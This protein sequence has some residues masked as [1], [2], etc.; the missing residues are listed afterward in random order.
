M[1]D[2]LGKRKLTL[3]LSLFANLSDSKS[4]NVNFDSR[5][6]S[7]S[8]R[9][10]EREVVGL[11]IVAAMNDSKDGSDSIISVKSSRAAS[12]ATMSPRSRPIPIVPSSAKP[13]LEKDDVELSESYTCVISHLG[14]NSI[15]KR[16]YFD[17]KIAGS[18][19]TTILEVNSLS[20]GVFSESPL[21]HG[22]GYPAMVPFQTAD[23]L[24]SCHLCK[25]MLHGL[26]IFMYRGEKAFCSPECRYK[27]IVNDE[28]KEKWGL[29]VMKPLDYY[30]SP[31]SSPMMFFAGVAAA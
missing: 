6:S 23:F 8:P 9:N 19:G 31:C 10:F 14:N 11:G 30:A 20:S 1:A 13:M 3:N 7:K 24:N 25:K 2:T 15:K 29:G 16:E 21:S 28:H 26:D 18:Y 12:L 5:D 27:Q 4:P 22:K 17:D